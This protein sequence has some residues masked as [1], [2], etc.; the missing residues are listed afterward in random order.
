MRRK[1][2]VTTLLVLESTAIPHFSA[3]SH[4]SALVVISQG[5]AL[6][7]DHG[8]RVYRVFYGCEN[9]INH[10]RSVFQGYM[11]TKLR[12]E[13]VAT[14]E[15]A[16]S[17]HTHASHTFFSTYNTDAF[18]LKRRK[19]CGN[20]NARRGAGTVPPPQLCRLNSATALCSAYEAVCR[21]CDKNCC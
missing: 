5:T 19:Q 18:G 13:T 9:I 6:M 3:R 1:S 14:V 21:G 16:K 11:F 17:P 2:L 7:R 15:G 12:T 4:F 10:R 8:C 20:Q